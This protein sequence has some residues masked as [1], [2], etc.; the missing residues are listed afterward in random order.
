MSRTELL[1]GLAI[2]LALVIAQCPG[3]AVN[4]VSNTDSAGITYLAQH[5][6]SIPGGA[7]LLAKNDDPPPHKRDDPPRRGDDPPPHG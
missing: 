5:S 4:Q 1:T 2:I 7:V 6:L 3:W